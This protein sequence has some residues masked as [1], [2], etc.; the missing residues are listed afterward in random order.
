MLASELIIRTIRQAST[1]MTVV[2]LDRNVHYLWVRAGN[3]LAPEPPDARAA[4]HEA[5]IITHC[6]LLGIR[7]DQHD[8]TIWAALPVHASTAR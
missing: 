5:L 4:D 3:A 7:T 2:T 1:I 6:R 8:T